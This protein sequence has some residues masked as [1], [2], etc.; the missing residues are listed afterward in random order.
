ME[1]VFLNGEIVEVSDAKVAV[2]DSGFL[3]GMGLFE[4]MRAGGGKV[5][6]L[7]HHLDRLFRSCEALRVNNPYS[8]TQ[9]TEAIEKT[10]EANQ[11][12]DARMRLT[13]TNGV[14]GKGDMPESTLLITATNFVPYPPEYY[15]KGVGV[16]LTDVRIN[17][18]DPIV[19]H[20]TINYFSRLLVL[21]EAH[22]KKCAEALWFT[23][24]NKLS[25]GCVSNVFVVDGDV[26][27]TPSLET[28]VLPGTMRKRI[29]GIAEAN[30]IELE[31]KDLFVADLLEA[32][33]VFIT[34]VI[35]SI[36]PVIQVEAHAIGEGKPGKI[37][38]RLMG[39]LD[40]ELKK[41]SGE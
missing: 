27:M 18:M 8:K 21:N 6:G 37:T 22:E 2:S 26:V 29:C 19:S 3:Y 32:D 11:L 39:Y 10:L 28:P 17:A 4:T 25:E 7:E 38:R 31:E 24:D 13:L 16:V 40:K 15:E 9:I 30:S 12:K 41:E 35:M 36:L 23:T 14:L 5:F 33:E 20:K 34:N 1:K